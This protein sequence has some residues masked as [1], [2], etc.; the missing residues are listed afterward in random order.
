MTAYS[1]AI[2]S[3][4]KLPQD[5]GYIIMSALCRK[6]PFLHARGHY[7]IAPVRG[8][9]RDHGRSIQLDHN[10]V[11]HIRGLPAEAA[12]AIGSS[13][14][15]ASGQMIGLGKAVPVPL[16]PAPHLVSRQVVFD[17]IVNEAKFREEV[18]QIVGPEVQ[19]ST[20]RRRGL[21][22]KGRVFLGYSVT[23]A[24]LTPEQS[25]HI[26]N[27]GIGRFRSMGAGV[28]YPGSGRMRLVANS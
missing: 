11:L 9:R 6:F 23:L 18:Q 14:I 21:H 7:Q 28:F 27:T 20:G 12:E 1:Y 8:T 5:N 19:V 4:A 25:L 26:Q 15:L 13:W 10:S 2:E 17:N 16:T 3:R 22:C 24:G